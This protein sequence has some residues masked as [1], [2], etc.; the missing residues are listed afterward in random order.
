MLA[1]NESTLPPLEGRGHV[2][3]EQYEAD[4]RLDATE[5]FNLEQSVNDSP[6]WRAAAAQGNWIL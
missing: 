6:Q 4:A 1:S 5:P 2:H 3:H